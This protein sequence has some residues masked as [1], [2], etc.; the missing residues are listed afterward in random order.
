MSFIEINCHKNLIYVALYWILEISFR[1]SN[2]FK[3]EFFVIFKNDVLNEYAIQIKKI[4]GD[5]LAGFLVLYSH[6]S[7]KSK[8]VKE[9]KESNDKIDYIYIE[10]KLTPSKKSILIIIIISILEYLS[11]SRYWIAYT[12][13]DAEKEE[14]SHS[15]KRDMTYTV[16]ILMRYVFSIFLLKIRIF[17]HHKISFVIISVGFLFLL[18][19]DIIDFTCINNKIKLGHSFLFALICL[20]ASFLSPY[21]H[22]LI[23]Q[24]LLYINQEKIQFL[25]GILN[26]IV[27]LIVSIIFYFVSGQKLDP[28]FNVET[29]ICAII[30]ILFHGVKEFILL[31]VI[32]KIS[33]HSVSFLI[34]AK[35]VGN[36]IYEICK[37]F[38]DIEN[39]DED[40][41]FFIILQI[42]GMLIILIA[43]LIYDEVII[44]NKWNLDYF[45]KKRINERAEEEVNDEISD[46]DSLFPIITQKIEIEEITNKILKN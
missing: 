31:K 17:K 20:S 34:I 36:N 13:I 1:L 23:K 32:D 43:S 37:N 6:C 39:K 45:T 8:K 46:E 30:Y 2:K 38:R 14:L 7:S 4:A 33:A 21:E 25:R 9:K 35:S 44:I 26:S 29:K 3:P 42:V 18:V 22:T 12:I 5:L 27:L 41:F 19:A 28:I 15:L 24:L 11:Q 40:D 16:D 10:T